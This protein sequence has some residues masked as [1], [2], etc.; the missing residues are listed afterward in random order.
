MIKD[1]I[2]IIVRSEQTKYA[3]LD[4]FFLFPPIL[5]SATLSLDPVLLFGFLALLLENR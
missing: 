1:R 4:D 3:H 2:L 5:S